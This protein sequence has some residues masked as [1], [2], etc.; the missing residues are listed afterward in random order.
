[1]IWRSPCWKKICPPFNRIMIRPATPAD[2][3][4]LL[5]I[6]KAQSGYFEDCLMRT[7][8]TVFLVEDKGYCIY[9]R[10]PKY[11]PFAAMGLPETQDLNVAPAFR[12]QGLASMLLDHCEALA[13]AQGHTQIGIGVGLH[14][15]YGP[16]Q[17]LYARR[18]Y[19]PDGLGATYDRTPV[20]FAALRPMDD[21]LCLMLIK[22]LPPLGLHGALRDLK[23]GA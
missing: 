6:R 5:A 1:M 19:I 2:I 7:G 22:P 20:P 12:R 23:I 18:G 14:A 9:N 13:R 3:P 16:A 17:I 11:A 15:S 4:A 8:C 10:H 21:D